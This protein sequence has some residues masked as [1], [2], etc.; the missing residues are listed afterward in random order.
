M[1]SCFGELPPIAHVSK[2]GS[3]NFD[4]SLAV[5]RGGGDLAT[6]VAYRLHK[7]GFPIIVLE[8]PQPMVV[9]RTVALASAVLQGAAQVEDIEGR[10][11]DNPAEAAALARTGVIPVMVSP[12]LP[13]QLRPSILID[14]RMAK[15]NIDTS[16]E[17]APLVI[18]LGPGFAAGIH[19]H[20]VIETKRGHT[21]GRVIWQGTALPN[22]GTPGI[23]AGKGAERVIR[24]PAQGVV[25]W[26]KEIGDVVDTGDKLG[27]T[28]G[29]LVTAPFRGILRGLIAAGTDV[30]AGMKIG[31]LDAR[32]DLAA[33][34]TISDKALAIGGG[35]LEA[36]FS[37]MPIR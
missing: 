29:Q 20:A 35:V 32:M 16:I 33:C 18:A 31:D 34:F 10:L 25:S 9:R 27:N 6:G 36:V 24:A 14:A 23:V 2:I 11:V 3:M 21:L 37:R 30:P 7:V 5:I 28:G 4:D 26:Q 8:L 19:C 1:S 15:R 17:Q 13:D 12:T 22:T